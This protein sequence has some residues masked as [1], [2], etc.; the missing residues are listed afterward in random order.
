LPFE[1]CDLDYDGD[2]D[3]EDYIASIESLGKCSGEIVYNPLVDM[4]MDGCVDESDI[5]EFFQ[6][7]SDNDGIL[8][9]DDNC[10]NQRNGSSSGTCCR[11]SGKIPR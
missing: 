11:V 6:V 10:P 3:N 4:D 5:T 8:E 7:D 1:I 2:C 9:L